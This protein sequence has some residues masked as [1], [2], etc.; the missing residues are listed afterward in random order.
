MY[1][2][3]YFVYFLNFLAATTLPALLGA[4]ALVTSA[5]IAEVLHLGPTATAYQQIGAAPPF[6]VQ[7]L[8]GFALGYY[9]FLARGSDG[10]V[11]LW[12]WVI[13]A[14]WMLVG[15]AT[16]QPVTSATIS[17]WEY[18]FGTWWLRLPPSPVRSRWVIAQFTHTL[19]LFTSLAYSMGAFL[20]GRVDKA[21][22]AIL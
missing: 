4:G 11:A 15:I 2:P 14:A 13:P 6:L 12:V 21:T 20:R 17:V 3:K 22:A 9:F 1:F 8:L 19:P 18:F 5:E 10:W 7:T 16:W